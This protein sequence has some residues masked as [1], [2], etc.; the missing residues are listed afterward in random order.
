[1]A[2]THAKTILDLVGV[3]VKY[4]IAPPMHDHIAK[5]LGI[6]WTFHG[7]KCRTLDDSMNL[8]RSEETA[9]LAVT[10]PYNEHRHGWSQPPRRAGYNDRGMRQHVPRSVGLLQACEDE[11]RLV[12]DQGLSPR[13]GQPVVPRDCGCKC[14][15]LLSDPPLQILCVLEGQNL[16]ALI[17]LG[18]T[19]LAC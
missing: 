9:G 13:E 12:G 15:H 16:Q 4:S 5:S 19:V 7:A 1:M 6:P 8:A 3:G 2:Q 14:P 11:N 17:I 10:M 18:L